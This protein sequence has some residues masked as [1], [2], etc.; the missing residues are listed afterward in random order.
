M[1]QA[2]VLILADD[3]DFAV[4]DS[5]LKIDT[6]RSGGKGGQNVNKVSNAVHLRFDIAAS[7]LPQEMKQRLLQLNDQRVR[8]ETY[9]LPLVASSQYSFLGNFS[10]TVNLIFQ[11]AEE[12]GGGAREIGGHNAVRH[13]ERVAI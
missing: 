4:P 1:N 6:F 3:A 13:R 10:G 9:I 11:P 12:G 7:S 2:T 8:V 5:E